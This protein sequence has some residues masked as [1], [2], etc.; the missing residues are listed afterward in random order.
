MNNFVLLFVSAT[1]EAG[2]II[3][4][5]LHQGRQATAGLVGRVSVEPGGPACGRGQRG[6]LAV[7]ASNQALDQEADGVRV[8]AIFDRTVRG[9]RSAIDLLRH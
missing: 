9:D 2:F 7:L 6:C 8:E 3:D 5:R 1:I 4:G